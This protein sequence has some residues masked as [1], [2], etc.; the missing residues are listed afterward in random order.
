MTYVLF[1]E[2]LTDVFITTDEIKVKT[3]T[4]KGYSVKSFESSASAE[5]FIQDYLYD[6]I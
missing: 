5:K 3:F 2:N 6:E 1:D 4:D